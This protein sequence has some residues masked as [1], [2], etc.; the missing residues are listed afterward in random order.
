MA[1]I[2]A[3]LLVEGDVL[4]DGRIID[5][6]DRNTG[7]V[8]LEFADGQVKPFAW[9]QYVD[10]AEP[11]AASIARLRRAVASY[12][13]LLDGDDTADETVNIMRDVRVLLDSLEG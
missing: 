5:D 11:L 13:D 6:V 1:N 4:A 7:R 10:L 3:H 8:T 9:Y 12:G 2:A